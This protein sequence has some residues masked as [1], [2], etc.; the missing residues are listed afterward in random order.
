MW[1]GDEGLDAGWAV[2]LVGEPADA[3]RLTALGSSHLIGLARKV[4][5]E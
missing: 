1:H 2:A 4:A 3:G 5:R